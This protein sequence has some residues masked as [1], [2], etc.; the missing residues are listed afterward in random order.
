MRWEMSAWKQAAIFSAFLAFIVSIILSNEQTSK[1]YIFFA[2]IWL[3]VSITT[4]AFEICGLSSSGAGKPLGSMLCLSLTFLIDR[5]LGGL[6][7]GKSM[8][9]TI[10]FTSITILALIAIYYF[11]RK[12]KKKNA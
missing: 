5:L 12:S 2:Y 8:E 4:L 6:L 1:E 7:L 11:G 9:N 10:L 3:S